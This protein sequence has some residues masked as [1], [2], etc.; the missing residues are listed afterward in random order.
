VRR[1]ERGKH[2]E[3]VDHIAQ[4][5]DVL[6]PGLRLYGSN[7]HVSREFGEV[8][9]VEPGIHRRGRDVFVG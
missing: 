5:P 2:K 7:V 4:N 3:L 1:K 9:Y 8:G 6:E